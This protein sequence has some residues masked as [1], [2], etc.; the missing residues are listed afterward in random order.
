MADL[1][2]MTNVDSSNIYSIGHDPIAN[3]L[4]VRFKT[5]NTFIYEGV[6]PEHH[7]AM[8]AAPS[9][10]KYFHA[11]VKSAFKVRKAEEPGGA[12]M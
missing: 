11:N 6:G 3:E 9:V 7:A 5:G 12:T 1:P 8:I 2:E 4:H 10:G